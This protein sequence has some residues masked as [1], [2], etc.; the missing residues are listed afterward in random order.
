METFNKIIKVCL[1]RGD[2]SE[3]EIAHA[4]NCSR[5]SIQRWIDGSSAPHP[6]MHS[7][8]YAWILLKIIDKK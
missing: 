4:M 2:F 6:V 7:T 1:N 3:E 8:V 5:T